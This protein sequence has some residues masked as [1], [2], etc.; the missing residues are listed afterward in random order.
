[1]SLSITST[2]NSISID[3]TTNTITFSAPGPRGATGATGYG[4]PTGGATAAALFKNSAA[5][6]DTTFRAIAQSDVTDLTSALAAKLDTPGAWTQYTCTLTAST[7]NPNLGATGS[8]VGYYVQIGKI[9]HF[10]AYVS[11]LSTGISAGSG[12]Y[13]IALPVNA[14][15]ATIDRVVGGGWAYDASLGDLWLCNAIVRAAGYVSMQITS[16]TVFNLTEASPMAWASGDGIN[17]TGTYE[18]A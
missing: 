9:V 11:F 8:A 18:A 7:T 12:T 3:A 15:T 2:S 5:D 10:R 6:Y 4:V 17:I 13:R 14:A 1:M 16:T